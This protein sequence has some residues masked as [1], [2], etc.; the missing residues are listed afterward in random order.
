MFINNS[1]GR[2]VSRD[3]IEADFSAMINNIYGDVFVGEI[4]YTTAETMRA[5]DP[6]GY[7]D[8]LE[9]FIRDEIDNGALTVSPIEAAMRGTWRESDTVHLLIRRGRFHAITCVSGQAYAAL[10]GGNPCELP[11]FDGDRLSDWR[12]LTSQN[13][14]TD[15]Y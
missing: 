3:E 7:A 13:L 2:A 8:R 15:N 6:N 5:V 9:A 14:A 11:P 10:T 12:R 4:R 1:T